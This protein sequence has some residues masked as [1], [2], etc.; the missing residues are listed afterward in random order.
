M[1]YLNG[2]RSMAPQVCLLCGG[3]EHHPIL[4]ECGIDILRCCKCHHVFSS[5]KADPF[6][7][8]FWGGHV[9]EGEH[10]Y[11]NKARSRMYQ[12]FHRQ[13]IVGRSGRLLDFGCGL[14]FFLKSMAQYENWES[15]GCE[16][17]PVAVR[18]ARETLALKNINCGRLEDSDFPTGSFDLIT[19]WDVLEH[20]PQPEYVLRR[21]HAL[22]KNGGRLFIRTPNVSIQLFKARLRRLFR[23][24]E[25]NTSYLQVKDHAH[26]YSKSSI[27][28]LLKRY[29]FSR[30]E[31]VHL[32]PV[33]DCSGSLSSVCR[34]ITRAMF[35]V[36]KVLAGASNGHLNFDNLFVLAEKQS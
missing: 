32:H 29:G 10:P 27:Q 19:M 30:I 26:H 21:C 24:A 22:L 18:Y 33:E 8:G 15:K 17:S 4:C 34:G 31:F 20:M 9:P 7:D 3:G 28:E 1:M 6:Y 13:F 5:F 35:I 36:V 23:G 25:N 14:G 16:I 12:D 2:D 11:W